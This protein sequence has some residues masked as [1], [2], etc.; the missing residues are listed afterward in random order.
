M[1]SSSTPLQDFGRKNLVLVEWEEPP[2]Q[3]TEAPIINRSTWHPGVLKLM[4]DGMA[5]E[6]EYMNILIRPQ[7]LYYKQV[8]K[9]KM[10]KMLLFIICEVPKKISTIFKPFSAIFTLF[11]LKNWPYLQKPKFGNLAKTRF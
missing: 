7:F 9:L 5:L 8:N 1:S 3:N 10:S 11:H 2:L 4:M 6:R